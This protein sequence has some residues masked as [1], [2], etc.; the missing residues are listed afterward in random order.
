[1]SFYSLQ[2]FKNIGNSTIKY[3]FNTIEILYNDIRL[4]KL[5]WNLFINN[6]RAEKMIINDIKKEFGNDVVII[7]G[8]LSINKQI[9]KQT[10][11]TYTG[12]FARTLISA[13]SELTFGVTLVPSPVPWPGPVSPLVLL[14]WLW[15]SSSS[16][17][18]SIE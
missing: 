10:K 2:D 7:L 14:S 9:I 12:R 16:S 1:M 5:K 6:K 3:L 15:S 18:L 17:L 4:N 13:I 11:W 8:D